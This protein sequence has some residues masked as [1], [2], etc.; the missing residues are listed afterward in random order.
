MDLVVLSFAPALPDRRATEI[1][2]FLGVEAVSIALKPSDVRDRIAAGIVPRSRC[3]I[4]DAETLVEAN[5]SGDGVLE[6][7]VGSAGCVFTYGW[8]PTR[9]HAAVLKVLSSGALVG[10]SRSGPGSFFEVVETSRPWAGPLAGIS[11]KAP[12]P[13]KESA[14][15]IGQSSPRDVLIRLGGKP[16]LAVGEHCGSH[17]YFAASSL[18]DLDME[19]PGDTSLLALFSSVMPLMMFLRGTLGD[20]VWRNERPQACWIIDD[21]LLEK[22]YGFLDY[23]RLSEAMRRQH[24]AAC[25]AFIPWNYRRSRK[26]VAGP[27]LSA[28]STYLCVHGCDHTGAEFATRNRDSLIGKAHLALERMRAH[29]RLSGVPFDDVMVFPQGRFSE[30]A[31]EALKAAGYMAALNTHLQPS[32]RQEGLP[33]RDLLSVAVMRFADFPLFGRRYPREIADVA[34]DLFLGKP[35]FLVEHHGYFRD[36][37]GNL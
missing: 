36:G 27:L 30:E 34:L 1:A 19:V 29:S 7:L 9:P 11:F 22:R 16:F 15:A 6:A 2:A 4:V 20:R 25:I 37:Y 14:F 31:L 21:P 13:G 3:L 32:T 24:S 12:E 8:R 5:R 18:A 17:V 35:A 26:E 33:I 23:A 10:L 28:S